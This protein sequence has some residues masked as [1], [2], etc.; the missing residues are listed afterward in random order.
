[1]KPHRAELPPTANG[2]G[3]IS[4]RKLNRDGIEAVEKEQAAAESDRPRDVA[5]VDHSREPCGMRGLAH[6]GPECPGRP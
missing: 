2:L 4:G 5:T 1:M 3:N 6:T